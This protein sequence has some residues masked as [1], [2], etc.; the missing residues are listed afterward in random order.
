MLFSWRNCHELTDSLLTIIED[1][2]GRRIALGFKK[3]DHVKSSGQSGLSIKD[4][5][6]KI[7]QLLLVNHPSCKWADNSPEELQNIIKQRVY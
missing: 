3:S 2:E 4:H 6:T 7:A 1:N 5:C